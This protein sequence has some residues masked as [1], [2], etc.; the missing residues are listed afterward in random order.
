MQQKFLN[1][2]ILSASLRIIGHKPLTLSA[3]FNRFKF[4]VFYGMYF[5]AQKVQHFLCCKENLFI[6]K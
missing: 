2:P 1:W 4:S 5:T 6:D 3:Y